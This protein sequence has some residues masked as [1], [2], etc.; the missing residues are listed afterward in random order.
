MLRE[1]APPGATAEVLDELA[2]HMRLAPD[3]AADQTAD[4]TDVFQASVAHLE[5]TLGLCLAPRSFSWRAAL[6]EAGSARAP[7]GPVRALT[8]AVEVT[9]GADTAV[10]EFTLD[11]SE[12]RT[13]IRSASQRG[14]HFFFTFD[15]GFGETWSDTPA[16][17]RR[18]TLMLAAHYYDQRHAAGGDTREAVYG[19]ASLIQPWR[20]VHVTLGAGA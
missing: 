3:F 1:T 5:A 8:E 20:P 9:E 19:V 12:T 14:R 13:V 11:Q 18:A 17:L 6:D 2:R 16:N 10:G 4:L 15:A 7:I